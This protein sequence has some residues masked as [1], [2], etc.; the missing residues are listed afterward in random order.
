[1]PE[2][3]K[4]RFFWNLYSFC[5]DSISRLTPYVEM[6]SEIA[7][8]SAC[9]PGSSLLEAGCGTGNFVKMISREN[10]RPAITA[11]DASTAM[12][13]RAREKCHGDEI[14]W[15]QADLNRRLPF[16]DGSFDRITC[17]NVLYALEKPADALME[18][19]RVLKPG[20]ILVLTTPQSMGNTDPILK[21]HLRGIRGIAGWLRFAVGLAAPLAIATAFNKIIKRKSRAGT[22]HFFSREALAALFSELTFADVTIEPTYAEQSWLATAAKPADSRTSNPEKTKEQAA[23]L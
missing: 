9:P 19:R 10:R 6:Q 13:A 3:L 17:T 18:L 12:L 22:Y 16:E 21:A 4:E 20:G 23:A 15:L 2:N 7:R 14:R 1:M 5:Y 11:V 8:R